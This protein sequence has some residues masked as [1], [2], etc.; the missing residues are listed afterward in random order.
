MKKEFKLVQCIKP[1]KYLEMNQTYLVEEIEVFQGNC[2]DIFN[3]GKRYLVK[4]HKHLTLTVSTKR[5]KI[6]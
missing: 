6:L 3:Y 4:I 5:F 2:N 1:T